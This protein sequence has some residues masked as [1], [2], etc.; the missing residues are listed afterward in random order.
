MSDPIRVGGEMV[1]CPRCGNLWHTSE[2]HDC[3][4][5]APPDGAPP[6]PSEAA[7]RAVFHRLYCRFPKRD[8]TFR[9]RDDSDR[10][11]RLYDAV[12]AAYKIDFGRPSEPGTTAR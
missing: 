8:S 7:V 6:E 2:D 1:T 9:F 10:W 4:V 3:P 5:A 11:V 12:H